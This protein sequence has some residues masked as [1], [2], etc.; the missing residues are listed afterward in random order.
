MHFKKSVNSSK[1]NMFKI[2]LQC[3]KRKYFLQF[4][5]QKMFSFS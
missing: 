3:K 4:N 5:A 2:N 1:K